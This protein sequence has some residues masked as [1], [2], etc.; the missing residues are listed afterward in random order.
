MPTHPTYRPDP[1]RTLFRC[2]L[3]MFFVLAGINHFRRP[4]IYLAM[5][6]TWVPGPGLVNA[7]CGA[8]E[9]LGGVALL[10]PVLRVAA[11]WCLIAL[12]LAVLPANL[13]VALMGHMP[14][15][16]F[17]PTLLWVRIPLQFVL[18]A[19]VAWVAFPNARDKRW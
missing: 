1:L 12:L 9:I 16:S 3:A 6:P 8:C 14:G 10:F 4:E 15:F 17:S 19:L 13:H 11:G 2:L 18:V 7:L 5:T